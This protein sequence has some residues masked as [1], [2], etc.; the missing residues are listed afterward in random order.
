MGVWWSDEYWVKVLQ[1][2]LCLGDWVSN[3]VITAWMLRGKKGY[4][5][6]D[7]RK[8]RHIQACSSQNSGIEL[9]NRTKGSKN[10]ISGQTHRP[11]KWQA[12]YLVFNILPC[13]YIE[14]GCKSCLQYIMRFKPLLHFPF[15]LFMYWDWLPLN[16]WILWIPI[17]LLFYTDVHTTQ[18]HVVQ[19]AVFTYLG[20]IRKPNKASRR[21]DILLW[22]YM[23]YGYQRTHVNHH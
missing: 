7:Y 16:F 21:E 18:I 17:W 10:Q 19:P 4:Q 8:H 14:M 23:C 6:Y 9:A 3:R 1:N 20:P 12:Q 5:T 13:C 15:F 2:A 11:R 22:K